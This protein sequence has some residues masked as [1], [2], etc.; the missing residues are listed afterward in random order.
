MIV[1]FQISGS[2]QHEMLYSKIRLKEV[3]MR[4]SG[5]LYEII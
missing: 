3:E 5:A 4:D 2:T 1:V